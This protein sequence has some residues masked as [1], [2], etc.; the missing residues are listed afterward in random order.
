MFL[1]VL[2]RQYTKPSQ[3]TKTFKTHILC[4][5]IYYTFFT[6]IG[7]LKIFYPLVTMF[8]AMFILFCLVI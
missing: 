6:N 5:D 7:Q 3:L 4:L 8:E 1:L 2:K